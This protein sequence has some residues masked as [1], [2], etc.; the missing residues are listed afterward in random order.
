[1][2]NPGAVFRDEL[3]AQIKSWDLEGVDIFKEVCAG[4]RFV[5]QKRYI[6]IVLRKGGKSL[7]IEAKTQQ[8]PGTAYQKLTYAIEDAKKTPIATIIAFSGTGIDQDVKA[9]LISSGI[10]LEVEWSP[11]KGFGAGLDML[12][13]RVMM[14][15]GLD[16]LS[17]QRD[18]KVS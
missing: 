13:Q 2:A 11:D 4:S 8:T 1:M 3:I 16:W 6:D 5:G 18:K 14:E 10:G 9:Q 15:L 17:D 12:K 7:G